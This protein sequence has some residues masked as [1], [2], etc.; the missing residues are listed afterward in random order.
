MIYLKNSITKDELKDM[1]LYVAE[2]IVNSEDYLTV[3]DKRIGD[4]DHGTGMSLGFREVIKELG[5]KNF[6]DTNEV[7]HCV[8]MT[9]LDTMGGASGVLFGTVFISGIVGYESK[10]TIDLKGFAEIFEKS[11]AALKRRGKANI[12]DKTMIDAFQPATEALLQGSKDSLSLVEGF[13][14]ALEKAKEGM[15]YTKQCV[16]KFGRAKSYGKMAIGFE[17]AGATSVWIIFRSMSEWLRVH[18]E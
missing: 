5:S 8:G 15:E 1:F 18:C 10:K 14:N 3:I 2:Q 9:L 4:G 6:S 13:N 17:D 11:L 7:F 12:G 16:A